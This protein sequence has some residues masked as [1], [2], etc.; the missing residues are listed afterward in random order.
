MRQRFLRRA[1]L[2][3]GAGAAALIAASAGLG[4]YVA[5]TLT[6]PKRPSH[7]DSYVVTPFETGVPAE[8]IRIPTE[9]PQRTLEGWWFPRPETDRVIITCTGYRG[10][11]S[12]MIGIGSALWRAG[13]NVLLFD[14]H[15]HGAGHGAP[16]TLAYRELRDF[17]AAL[18]YALARVPN[19]RL[20][21]IGFSMG[22]AVAVQ[23]AARR[24][25]VRA[26]VADSPF[27]THADV[28]AHN[29]ERV[30]R[31]GGAPIARIADVF[32]E[33]LA[34]YVSSDVEPLR[35]APQI[36]PRPLLLIHGSDDEM[37][38]VSHAYRMFAAA[39]EPKEL[40]ISQGANHCG[41]YFLDRPRYCQ[42]VTAFFE[43]AL[44]ATS[45][46]VQLHERAEHPLTSPENAR[47]A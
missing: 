30:T 33:R 21:A 28:V 3:G 42:R 26:V 35:A 10:S 9:T 22:A 1:A 24:P 16:V 34:G 17:D 2:I 32:L 41:T 7:L 37:I 15:G 25:E 27:A 47:G 5:W 8:D 12:D 36:A 18:N 29:V 19:A 4:Y 20:G 39:K 44:G 45:A 40:W 38:P 23:G 13:F 11:K 46:P 14:Y 31:L 6:A 43:Q